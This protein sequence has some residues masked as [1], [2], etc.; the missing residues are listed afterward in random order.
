[1][2]VLKSDSVDIYRKSVGG[3]TMP[4]AARASVVLILCMMGEFAP[5]F[6]DL[7][8]YFISYYFCC[9]VLLQEYLISQQLY[10]MKVHFEFLARTFWSIYVYCSC[11]VIFWTFSVYKSSCTGL[12]F[13]QNISNCTFPFI[14]VFSCS[15]FCSLYTVSFDC[16]VILANKLGFFS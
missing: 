3:D 16:Q 11:F 6:I 4:L 13:I 7:V 12:N 15:S 2:P 5:L 1:M 9:T 14:F 10:L 8:V